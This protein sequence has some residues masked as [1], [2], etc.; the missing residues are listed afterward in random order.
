MT[1]SFCSCINSKNIN[2]LN[3][4]FSV[5]YPVYEVK[6]IAIYFT[7]EVTKMFNINNIDIIL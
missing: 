5:A 3:R 4:T 2:V 1:V 6:E 7:T